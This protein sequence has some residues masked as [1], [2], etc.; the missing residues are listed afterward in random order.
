VREPLEFN[1][2]HNFARFRF[3]VIVGQQLDFCAGAFLRPERFAT[4]TD[5]VFDDGI[6]G[7]EN[8]RGAAIILF[9]LDDFDLRKI[10]SMF[11]RLATSAPRQP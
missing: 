5:I 3:I 10:F 6:R 7:V 1:L 8:G 11:S 4:A 2:R 9:Q